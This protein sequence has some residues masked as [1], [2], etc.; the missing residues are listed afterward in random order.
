MAAA[1]AAAVADTT[2]LPPPYPP[3]YLRLISD[4]HI[5]LAPVS[6]LT[7]RCLFHIW[8]VSLASLTVWIVDFSGFSRSRTLVAR[9]IY[10]EGSLAAPIRYTLMGLPLRFSFP[11]HMYFLLALVR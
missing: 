10:G 2:L 6:T 11:E 3:F 5:H 8:V 9:F 7:V 1:A 4:K